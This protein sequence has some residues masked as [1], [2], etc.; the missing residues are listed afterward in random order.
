MHQKYELLTI[1]ANIKSHFL[2]DKENINKSMFSQRR[3]W[4][5]CSLNSFNHGENTLKFS[6]YWD[7]EYQQCITEHWTDLN[8][9]HIARVQAG[10]FK[11]AELFR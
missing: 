6:F 5:N 1:D 11:I 7:I 2:I 8:Y 9:S 4:C 3:F 10:T